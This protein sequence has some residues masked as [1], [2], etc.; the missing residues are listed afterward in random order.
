MDQSSFAQT[1]H[2]VT[3]VTS[4]SPPVYYFH[5]TLFDSY[6]AVYHPFILFRNHIRP[7]RGTNC[8]RDSIHD[9]ATAHVNI[10]SAAPENAFSAAPLPRKRR[11]G[12]RWSDAL[13]LRQI[14]LQHF[15]KVFWSPL[16]YSH[17]IMSNQEH[18]PAHPQQNMKTYRL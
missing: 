17:T 1:R 7:Q 5:F 6:H 18:R 13:H 15:R 14:R 11:L 10:R 9:I 16:Q 2:D 4:E 3:T 8:Q 12:S